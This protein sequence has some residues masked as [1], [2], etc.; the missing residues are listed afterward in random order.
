MKVKDA[1]T[2]DV[3]YANPETSIRQVAQLMKDYDCGSIPVAE[4]DKLIGM[5]TDRDI[6][7]RCVAQDHDPLSM[8]AKECMSSGMLYCYEDENVEDVLENM[9]EQA[10]KRMPVVNKDKKL[11]GIVSFGDLSACC[12]NKIWAGEAME[13][14]R[15]AA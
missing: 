10:V 13:N 3:Q 15:E 4:N 8:T 5:I 14:I 7:L 2:K 11:V 9:G 1:L 12:E 6:I